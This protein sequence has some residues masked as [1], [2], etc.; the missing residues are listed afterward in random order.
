M[1]GYPGKSARRR[2]VARMVFLAA[3][4]VTLLAGV[5]VAGLYQ[6]QIRGCYYAARLVA[7]GDGA[8]AEEIW[9]LGEAGAPAYRLAYGL[10]SDVKTKRAAANALGECAGLGELNVLVEEVG[11]GSPAEEALVA[12]IADR[13]EPPEPVPPRGV[14]V[15]E[16]D[17]S[18]P[19]EGLKVLS[20]GGNKKLAL[21]YV[22]GSYEAE[23]HVLWHRSMAMGGDGRGKT[24]E[25]WGPWFRGGTS[26]TVNRK[27]PDGE[28]ALIKTLDRWHRSH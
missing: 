7:S 27:G 16:D 18:P 8:W 3:G 13:A 23:V 2:D 22:V 19:P 15:L 14:E 26:L 24:W 5:A 21:R 4:L 28:R 9:F 10:S 1:A 17:E 20:P 11:V 25:R 12:L 6:E